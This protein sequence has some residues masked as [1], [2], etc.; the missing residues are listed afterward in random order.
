MR[1]RTTLRLATAQ[2]ALS[3]LAAGAQAP[4]ALRVDADSFRCM[5]QMSPVRGF[6]VDNLAGKLDE[7]LAV[8]RSASGGVYPVGSVVQLVPTEVM[9]KLP[10]GSS[11]ATRDWEFFELQVSPQGT[12]IG[13]RG[14]ADVVNQFGGNC[15]ACHVQAQPQWDLV[16]EQGHGCL[17]IPL[18]AQ[19]T[20][21][22]QRADPRCS[23]PNPLSAEDLAALKQLQDA[24]AGRKP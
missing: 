13:K 4:A 7:T 8:A 18:T 22:L 15:F 20:R 17:P 3:A 23:P 12:R 24:L 5:T 2:A 21:A 16:C 11:P 9:V 14:F 6:Y 19:M 1:L 10:A